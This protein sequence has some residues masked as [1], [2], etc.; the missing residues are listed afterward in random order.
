MH[1][2]YFAIIKLII[3]TII[4]RLQDI[5]QFAYFHFNESPSLVLACM[6][7]LHLRTFVTEYIYYFFK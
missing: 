6:S 2:S 7:L 4:K 3:K 5:K 1:G